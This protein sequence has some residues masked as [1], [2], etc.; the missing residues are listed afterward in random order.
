MGRF[1][2]RLP[3]SLHKELEE[4]AG[5]EGVSLNQYIVYALTQ[6]VTTEKLKQRV[7]PDV[8]PVALAEAVEQ[9]VAF[10]RLKAGLGKVGTEAEIQQ[11]LSEREEVEPEAEIEP[12]AIRRFEERISRANGQGSGV[13]TNGSGT[14]CGVCLAQLLSYT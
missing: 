13:V 4:R 7:L 9:Y 5:H 6:Q 12:E 14:A 8:R 11:Y 2:L 1:T 10:E 3:K